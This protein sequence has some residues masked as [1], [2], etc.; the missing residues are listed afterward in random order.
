MEIKPLHYILRTEGFT[1][2]NKKLIVLETYFG[3]KHTEHIIST[4]QL[5]KFLENPFCHFHI[6][7]IESSLMGIIF[8]NLNC[9]NKMDIVKYLYARIEYIDYLQLQF[10]AAYV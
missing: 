3:N 4:D 1:E 10:S 6:Q 8:E 5:I 7:R 2:R 9:F